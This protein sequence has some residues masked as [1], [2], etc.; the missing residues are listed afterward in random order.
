[1][2]LVKDVKGNKRGFCKF[3][4]RRMRAKKK[5]AGLLFSE[6]GDSD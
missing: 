1:M 5:N 4:H 2:N 6:A 3:I